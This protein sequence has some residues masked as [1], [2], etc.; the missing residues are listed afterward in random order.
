MQFDSVGAISDNQSHT[1]PNG[2]DT[3]PMP[4]RNRT[5]QLLLAKLH[6]REA[7]RQAAYDAGYRDGRQ[8]LLAALECAPHQLRQ[9]REV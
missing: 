6:R 4:T 5:L 9:Q 7:A 2:G 1:K 8:S 3:K